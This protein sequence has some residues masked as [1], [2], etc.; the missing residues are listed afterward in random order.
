MPMDQLA[1]RV[2]GGDHP[3]HHVLAVEDGA[4]DLE[5]RLPGEARKLTEQSAVEAEEQAQAFWDRPDELAV[6][7]GGA[8]ITRDVLGDENRPVLIGYGVPRGA[9]GQPR[10]VEKPCIYPGA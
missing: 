1:K 2:D 9:L 10:K 5:Y 8:D 4:V 6:G 3:R 7:H